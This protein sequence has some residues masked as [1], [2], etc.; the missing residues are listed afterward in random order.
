[1]KNHNPQ[2]TSETAALV[3]TLAADLRRLTEEGS[4]T[5]N[6]FLIIG[7]NPARNYYVQFL[8]SVG[9]AVMLAEAVSDAYVLGGPLTDDQRRRLRQLGWLKPTK[10]KRPN[11]WRRFSAIR[12]KD[13]TRMAELAVTTLERV[14]GWNVAEGQPA[15]KIH[16]A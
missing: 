15:V 1:L 5:G 13:F 10:K 14:Y 4:S 16:F 2:S 11:Y 12:D 7:C 3:A 8:S 6:N 9:S